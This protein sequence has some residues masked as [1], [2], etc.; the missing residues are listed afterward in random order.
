MG[1]FEEAIWKAGRKASASNSPGLS[2]WEIPQEVTKGTAFVTFGLPTPL[3]LYL[4][5]QSNLKI[6][7]STTVTSSEENVTSKLSENLRCKRCIQCESESLSAFFAIEQE[8]RP[9]EYWHAIIAVCLA[10]RR[11]HLERTYRDSGD[12]E[13]AFDQTEWYL[14]DEVSMERVRE[15]VQQ[16]NTDGTFHRK[17]SPCPEPLSPK[18]LCAVHWQLIEAVK[19]LEPLTDEEMRIF[20]GVVALRFS[21]EKAG[22][23]RFE[24]SN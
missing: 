20:G 16:S 18:C 5:S 3:P 10:C 14:L 17:L 23:P 24:R 12:R 6:H 15:F 7:L 21:L 1:C 13:D 8:E 19:R 9:P 22:F 2:G 4:S 11:G